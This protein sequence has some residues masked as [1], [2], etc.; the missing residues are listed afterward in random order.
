[1]S[2]GLY[3]VLTSDK[4]IVT[5]HVNFLENEFPGMSL[6]NGQP[7]GSQETVL[8]GQVGERETGFDNHLSNTSIKST[9]DSCDELQTDIGTTCN[10]VEDGSSADASTDEQGQSSVSIWEN[11]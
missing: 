9:R 4:I 11:H 3:R 2:G 1:M 8:D 5:N 10:I 7:N 6:L